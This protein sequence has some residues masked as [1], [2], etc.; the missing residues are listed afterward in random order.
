[1]GIQP[2]L[3]FKLFFSLIHRS[4][5][6]LRI[7]HELFTYLYVILRQKG[8]ESVESLT[9]AFVINSKIKNVKVKIV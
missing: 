4:F 5:M 9:P 3:I 2:Y 8:F 1:M 7:I 6:P